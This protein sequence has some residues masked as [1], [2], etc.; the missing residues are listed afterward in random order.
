VGTIRA[1][2]EALTLVLRSLAPFLAELAIEARSRRI[3]AQYR[4]RVDGVSNALAKESH[5]DVAAAWAA[6]DDDLLSG[7]I[8]TEDHS[9]GEG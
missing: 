6:F 8:T 9:G 3:E 4:E 7:G 2:L 5:V 1:L